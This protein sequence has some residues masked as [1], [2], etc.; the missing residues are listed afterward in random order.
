MRKANFGASASCASA[1]SPA[2]FSGLSDSISKGRLS[3]RTSDLG[4]FTRALPR[5]ARESNVSILEVHPADESLESVFSY[6][7]QG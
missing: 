6:L 1:F 7:V 5:L 2:L 4:A 3:I